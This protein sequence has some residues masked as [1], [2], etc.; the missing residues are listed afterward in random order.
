M[1]NNCIAKRCKLLPSREFR[2]FV[3]QNVLIAVCQRDSA[4]FYPHLLE[5]R[6]SLSDVIDSFFLCNIKDKFP[7]PDFVMDIYVDQKLRVWIVDFGVYGIMSDP[8]LFDWKEIDEIDVGDDIDGSF[9][10]E[11]RIVETQAG[12]LPSDQCYFGLPKDLLDISTPV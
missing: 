4:N 9:D 8:L 3:R 12:I 1:L 2:C 5:A 6:D 7:S 10:F 11:L